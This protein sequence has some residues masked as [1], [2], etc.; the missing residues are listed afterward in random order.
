V[1]ENFDP[2]KKYVAVEDIDPDFFSDQSV[3]TSVQDRYASLCNILRGY[4]EFILNLEGII[5]SSNLEAVNITGYEEWEI[6][7]KHFSIFYP[8]EDNALGRPDEDLVTV[9]DYGKIFYSG[10]R[11]KKKGISFW[12]KIRITA[13]RDDNQQVSGYRMV[14]KDTTHNAIY[15]YRVKRVRDEYLNLFN[16]TFIGIFKFRIEDFK[17]LLLNEKASQLLNAKEFEQSAFYEYFAEKKN[18]T[19]FIEELKQKGFVEN[20]EVQLIS[21]GTW[22]S[23]SCRYFEEHG[24]AEG[25][26]TDITEKKKQLAELQRLNQEIDKFIYHSSHDLRSPLTTIMGLTHLIQLDNPVNNRTTEYNGMIQNQVQHLDILLKSLVNITF[27]NKTE[28]LHE[29]IDFEKE[30]EIILREFRHQYQ[31]VKVITQFD[32]ALKFYSDPVRLHIILK[33]LISNAFRFHNPHSAFAF[34]KIY[35]KTEPHHN[36]IIVEDNGIGIDNQYLGN[37]F[38]MFYKAERGSAGLGL[39]IVKSMVEKL[40]GKIQVESKRWVGSEFRVCLPLIEN[41]NKFI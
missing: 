20:L 38:N 39:Y 2:T 37:I 13:L 3:T 7:S 14:I 24:F 6:M 36:V 30:V 11:V 32:S 12:A 1:K 33:N 27:N 23:I 28:P 29:V 26:L 41:K 22:L 25:I 40:G 31:G 17:I 9:R 16:N 15:N 34:I 21:E 8:N 4:E 10:W 5:I 19:S 18:F 35:L